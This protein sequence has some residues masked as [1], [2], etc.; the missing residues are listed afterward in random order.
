MI[1][2]NQRDKIEWKE[3]FSVSDLFMEM[4]YDYSLITVTI[5]DKYIPEEDYSSTIIPD[6][7]DVRAYHLAHGG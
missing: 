7:A 4:G 1:T 5:N 2:V 6:N 3:N